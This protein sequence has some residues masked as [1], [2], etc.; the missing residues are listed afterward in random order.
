MANQTSDAR[1]TVTCR[2]L[3]NKGMYIDAE[4]DP[5]VPNP[6]DGHYWCIHTMTLLGPDGKVAEPVACGPGRSCHDPL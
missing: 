4:P 3:R 5:L 2:C 6:H 1:R